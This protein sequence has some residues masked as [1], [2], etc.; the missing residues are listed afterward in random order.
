MRISIDIDGDLL[1][2][3]MRCS[4]ER[5]EKEAVVEGLRALAG[6]RPQ[7]GIQ[8]LRGR[9]MWEGDLDLS[10]RE[11]ILPAPTSKRRSKASPLDVKGV[12]LGVSTA[13]LVAIVREGRERG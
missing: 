7:D 1:R 11:R 8:H 9:V 3:A 13:E 12:K 5:T 6:I 4:G 2:E 10:R